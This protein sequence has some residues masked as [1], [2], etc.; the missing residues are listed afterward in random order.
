MCDWIWLRE[1][2]IDRKGGGKRSRMSGHWGMVCVIKLVA[3]RF[4]YI[5]HFELAHE[6]TSNA[7]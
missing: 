5:I 6:E 2:S 4:S 1:K 3:Q 7:S